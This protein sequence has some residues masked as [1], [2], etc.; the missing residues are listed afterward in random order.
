MLFAKYSHVFLFLTKILLEGT[1]T[2]P[3]FCLHGL[4]QRVTC[5]QPSLMLW[6]SQWPSGDFF[7][8][9]ISTCKMILWGPVNI[10]F[11]NT[12]LMV[13]F[14]KKGLLYY[15]LISISCGGGMWCEYMCLNVQ[16][17]LEAW[18]GCGSAVL[19]LVGGCEQPDWGVLGTKLGSSE[20]TPCAL[21]FWAIPLAP[22]SL[23]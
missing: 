13:L 15:L 8:W 22:A 3:S 16:V 23:F 11:S 7:S 6:L 12:F 10:P 2:W 20:R 5:A 4:W 19:G 9:L 17:P 1:M 14:L 21:N 18:R